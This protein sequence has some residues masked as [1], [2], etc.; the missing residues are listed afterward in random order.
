MLGGC[1]QAGSSHDAGKIYYVFS[2]YLHPSYRAC[3]DESGACWEQCGMG[4]ISHLNKLCHNA[5][6]LIEMT[7][8]ASKACDITGIY[9]NLRSFH[10]KPAFPGAQLTLNQHSVGTHS[11]L[12]KVFACQ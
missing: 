3:A 8:R 5:R 4:N 7:F 10:L 2:G 12:N 1:V 11:A 9:Q 6:G